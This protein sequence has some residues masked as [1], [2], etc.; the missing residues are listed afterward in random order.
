[1]AATAQ[2]FGISIGVNAAF[3]LLM[4]FIFSVLRMTKYFGKFYCAKRYIPAVWCCRSISLA[5]GA[6][7]GL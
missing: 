1:M 6:A 4:F 5:L 3:G 7:Y 2:S